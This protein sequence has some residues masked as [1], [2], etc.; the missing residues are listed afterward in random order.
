MVGSLYVSDPDMW[1]EFY[2]Q[3]NTGNV[4]IPKYKRRQK[5]GGIGG[6]YRRRRYMI[7]ANVKKRDKVVVGTQVTPVAAALERAKSELKTAIEEKSPHVT[8]EKPIKEK[9]KR[10]P[11]I[12]KKHST[13]RGPY[14]KRG[15]PAGRQN[16]TT[17]TQL[18]SRSVQKRK[19]PLEDPIPNLFSK[20]RWRT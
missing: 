17:K 18:K 9:T 14:R 1:D 12:R 15:K 10:K 6:M 7:P 5:G 19:R 4:E 20:K 2:K 16:H 11:S 8:V 13:T 3:L